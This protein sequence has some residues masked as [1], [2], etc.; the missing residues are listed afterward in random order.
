MGVKKW[1]PLFALL[2]LFAAG[3]TGLV[4]QNPKP[5][6]QSQPAKTESWDSKSP[7]L[8]AEAASDQGD[9]KGEKKEA[10]YKPFF[11]KPTD[12]LLVIFSGLLALYTWQ[13]YR[14]TKGLVDAAAEQSKDM[15]SSVEVARRSAEAAERTS[16]NQLRA[17]V[18][19]KTIQYGAGHF[20]NEYGALYIKEWLFWAEFENVGATPATDVRAW[21]QFQ[22]RSIDKD[23]QPNFVWCEGGATMVMGPRIPARTGYIVIPVEQMTALWQNEIEIYLGFRVEYR[24]TIDPS[25]VHHHEQCIL[26]ELIREPDVVEPQDSKNAPRVN[27]RPYGPQNSTS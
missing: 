15:K 2:G 23:L 18:F 4:I 12:T 21:A 14:A 27:L 7:K 13:L 1:G 22:T 17:F 11:E 5:H 16:R 20:T 8:I 6:Y 9:K 10:W 25:I 3:A 19:I 24:D 26:L